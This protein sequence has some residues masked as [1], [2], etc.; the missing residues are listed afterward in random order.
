MA[1]RKWTEKQR[2]AI[3]TRDRTL[4]VSAAAGSG[5]TATLTE[6]IIQ[7][8]MDENNRVSVE[9]LLVV[10]FTN[11]AANEL[12]A[13]ISAALEKAVS[14]NP[15]NH[16][17]E[18]QLFMLPQAK[19]RTIDSFLG[20]I[21]RANAD[22]VGVPFNYRIADV[23]E[24]HLIAE[25]ILGGLIEAVY[26][27]EEPE[28]AT[29]EEF[30]A[31]A[32]CLTD[33]KRADELS[34]VFRLIYEK[35]ESAEDGI[36]LV[37]RLG[38]LYN[39]ENYTS[40]EKT[41]HN[42]YLINVARKMLKHYID[43]A[44][45][46][47]PTFG[48]SETAAKLS[49]CAE[50]DLAV[51]DKIYSA[52][53]YESMREN[54]LS[55]SLK[56]RPSIT[57]DT[58]YS[59]QL[60]CTLRNDL[61]NDVAKKLRPLF[62]YTKEAWEKLLS[63]LYEK[64]GLLYRFLQRF[65]SLF[66]KEKLRR[67]AL[68][69]S[70]V[71]RFA[72]RCLVRDG[73]RTEVAENLMRSFDAIYIDEYQDVNALQNSVFE[74]ISRKDNRFMVGDIKQSIYGFRHARPQ[75]FADMKRSFAPLSE[76]KAGEE[77][78]VFMSDNFRC[79]KGVVD[80]VNS[81]FDKAFSL[82]GES[83]GY[84]DEDR[85]VYSKVYD[86]EPEYHSPEICM[87]DK[88]SDDE[89]FDEEGTD[90]EKAPLVVA[91]KIKELLENGRLADGRAV[92]PSDIAIILR[93]AKGKDHKYAEAL[94]R[95]GVPV[96]ISGAKSFF[97]S[98]E[99]LLALC[100]L[101]SVDNPRRDIYLAGL[102]C[103]PLYGFTPEE[104][105]LIRK[106]DKESCLFDALV[107][108]NKNH[109]EFS[110]GEKF[111]SELHRYRAISEGLG[112]DELLF[113]LY[114]ETGLLALASESGGKENLMIL[115]DYS[116]DFE[117]GEFKGLYNFIHF[118]NSLIDK[119]TTFDDARESSEEAA[120]RIVTCHASKGL[121]YPIVFMVNAGAPFTNKDS[122]NRLAFSAE[123]GIAMRL[124]TPSG[125]SVVNNPIFDLIN[126]YNFEKYTEEE[127]RVL[128]VALTRARER[129][130]VVGTSPKKD[131]DGYLEEI[132]YLRE[133]LSPY[134]MRKLRSY[135]EIILVTTGK[136]P[137]FPED[138]V[139]EKLH[140]D[141]GVS[142]GES[143]G[144]KSEDIKELSMELSERFKFEYPNKALTRL[145][146]K[147]SVSKT[148]PTVLDYATE[149][150]IDMTEEKADTDR[151]YLP[152]FIS[153]SRIEESARRGVA[154]HYFMQFCDLDK[155]LRDG[156]KKELS[157]LVSEGY[158]SP[159]D[160]ERVRLEEL[161]MFRN[162]QLFSE[163][164]A[165]Q[166]LHRELRFNTRLP[167][168]YFTTDEELISAYSG[169]EILVQGVIDCIIV[170]SDGTIGLYDYKTD[171][172]S[173]EELSDRE[174]GRQTLRKKHKTQLSYYSLAVEKMFGKAPD[175]VGIYSLHLGE[176]ILI[177]RDELQS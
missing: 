85:L 26:S 96:K 92:A 143:D 144:E 117:G 93:N 91:T 156:A 46:L 64:C 89:E 32:D 158:I 111:L 88:K 39:K 24:C 129:L 122:K 177:D 62:V 151:T 73:K 109:P 15:E 23:A 67:G 16:R 94:E 17:L 41:P 127:L 107:A 74:A 48:G 78:A 172:L 8:L 159:T 77:S 81:V 59:M 22:R 19:I 132:D 3:E 164:L 84:V 35:C 50:C 75:I 147:M 34:E 163:M 69:Y 98:S 72:Y 140:F 44:K 141:L 105:C 145:P 63:D 155:F 25:S 174:K 175:K 126:R 51:M 29:P 152:K 119:R 116:R 65:D 115:Y 70:D 45:E 30:E 167:A 171:R 55:F 56:T 31:L 103:S 4:L 154:T 114:H 170:G 169:R 104:L 130:F 9:N 128:Y 176:L 38:E 82:V 112:C 168:K 101:N 136:K 14:Q 71:E 157:R 134:S 150:V 43:V 148:S 10:T 12:R 86:L 11:A 7:S 52:E 161:E 57:K 95:V 79:D 118:I 87:L 47:L 110:K 49:E 20:D 58:N 83:I 5:K 165:A 40:L 108:Y 61:K 124:R 102:M 66:V 131:T 54:V 97:L 160:A 120:V 36:L 1:E 125:L 139:N 13:K 42:A 121:E 6:R 37:K 149:G 133:T 146:E 99:V 2:T 166:R 53:D 138:F 27:G 106:E 113:R 123:M 173:K 135:L 153:G 28:I 18:R 137:I 90:N 33:S 162:S 80:F 68:S 60:Y 100:L 142:C 76:A 21:L